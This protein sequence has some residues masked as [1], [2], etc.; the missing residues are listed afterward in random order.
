MY[1]FAGFDDYINQI[2]YFRNIVVKE[3]KNMKKLTGLLFALTML[4]SMAFI[5]G[6]TSENNPFSAQA[7]TRRGRVTVKRKHN[8]IATRTY[9]GGKYI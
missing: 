7:Q 8:G 1:E 2:N 3:S 6:V 5:G 4:L 9:R